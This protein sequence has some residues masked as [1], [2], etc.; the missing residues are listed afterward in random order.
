MLRPLTKSFIA[1]LVAVAAPLSIIEVAGAS[2]PKV[3]TA[4]GYDISF[5]QCSETLPSAPGFGI[6]GV[7]D[8]SPLTTNPC[9][10]RELLWAKVAQN[11]SPSFY[12][13][14]A[15]PG[16][17]YT[18]KWP[19]SQS[20]PQVCAGDNSSACSYDYGWN[21]AGV[22]FTNAV[23]AE[24]ANGSTSPASAAASTPWWLDV[25]TG[26]SWQTTEAQYAPTKASDTNDQA[27]LQGEIAYF[28]S[29]GASSVGIYSTTYQWTKI[30][31][32]SGTSFA[33]IP[34]WI[35]GAPTLSAAQSACGLSTFTGG[36]VK[37]T[38]YPSNG[39][40]GDY[41][42]GQALNANTGSTSVA[43]SSTFTDQLAASD[44][45]GA[46]TYTETTGAPALVV[47]SAGLMTT[48]GSLAL[49]TYSTSGTTVDASGV[50]GSY[51]FTLSVGLLAQGAPVSASTTT[52]RS[53]TFT[54][55]LALNGVTGTATYSQTSGSP[56]LV[57]SSSGHL[58]TSGALAP[59]A[60]TASGSVVDS[61]G[62]QGAFTFT[63]HVT[64]V[65]TPPP[66]A[67]VTP[68]AVAVVGHAV[69]GKTETLTI[70]GSGFYG[71]PRITSHV[72]T[73]AQVTKDTGTSLSVRVKVKSGSRKGV[74]QFTLTFAH[75]TTCTVKYLQR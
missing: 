41:V 64:S 17:A 11:S 3:S 62:D 53:S 72:R 54:S 8:G 45:N 40:D 2:V 31:G 24:T 29:V 32:G 30:T 47:S 42:C 74:F 75:G 4:T 65:T 67:P 18:T 39:F 9:L 21:S 37:M 25:E 46:L 49:G 13:N 23:N 55:Q 70:K 34:V 61:S 71:Q 15:N 50:A 66:S 48:S 35:P 68:K 58:S 14:T 69:A 27:M 16:P 57:V 5:P 56:S 51:S 44:A 38:Q 52:T 22:S 28:S 73:T 59:G 12:A 43:G 20:T 19:T 36:S 7:N 6:V 26:N 63:L 60:Y 33:S 1:I 10:S